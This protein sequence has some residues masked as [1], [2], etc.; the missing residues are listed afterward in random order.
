MTSQMMPRAGAGCGALFAVALIATSNG[1]ADAGDLALERHI[2]LGLV[3][4]DL[5]IWLPGAMAVMAG[6]PR[7]IYRHLAHSWG[8]RAPDRPR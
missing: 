4:P 8:G 2:P 1:S 6:C 5:G 7:F 3:S